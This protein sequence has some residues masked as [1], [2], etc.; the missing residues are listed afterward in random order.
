MRFLTL[1]FAHI[2]L[3]G[4]RLAAVRELADIWSFLGMDSKMLEEAVPP[5]ENLTALRDQATH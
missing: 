2:Y 5:L 3:L 4:E 1:V